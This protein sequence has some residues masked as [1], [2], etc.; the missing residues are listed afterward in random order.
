MKKILT[1]RNVLRSLKSNIISILGMCMAFAVAVFISIYVYHQLSIDRTQSNYDS[2]YRLELGNWASLTGGVIPW[3]AEQFP[4]V[5]S[6]ARIG[7]AF[8]ESTLEYENKYHSIDQVMFMDGEPFSVFDFNIIYGDPATALEPPN[9]IILTESV[10]RR[11]FN[12]QNPVGKVI[13]YNRDFPMVITAVI[14]DPEDIHLDFQAIINFRQLAGIAFGGSERYMTEIIGSQNYMG[15]FVLR[16]NGVEEL[17]EKIQSGLMEMNLYSESPPYSFRPFSNIYFADDIRPEMGVVHGNKQMVIALIFVA[18]F[19]LVIAT[20]NYINVSTAEGISRAREVG[21]KKL[22]GSDRKTLFAQFISESAILCLVSMIFAV[23]VILILYGWFQNRLGL[24][25]P[26]LTE[27]PAFMYLTLFG[28]LILVSIT[29]G[30]YP[31]LYLSSMKPGRLFTTSLQ[32]GGRGIVLRRILMLVQFIIAIFLTIQSIGIYKQY[33]YMKNSDPGIDIDRIIQFELPDYLAGRSDAI[34]EALKAHPDIEEISFSGQPLGSVRLT[35]TFISPVNQERIPF[36]LQTVDPEHIQVL[37]MEILSGTFFSRDMGSERNLSVVINET[38]AMA[39][40]CNPPESITGL[41][42]TVDGN[43]FTIIGVVK[44]Y[45]YNSLDIPIEPSLMIWRDGQLKASLRFNSNNIPGVIG[46]IEE[47]W[48]SFVPGKPLSYS[49]LEE[50]FN[51][52]YTGEQRLGRLVTLFTVIAVIIACFGVYGISAFMARKLSKNISLRK[53]MGAETITVVEHFAR[54]YFRLVVIAAIISIPLG[55]LYINHW[56]A[57]FPY[58]TNI[59]V[60]IFVVAFLLILFV[61][62]LTILYHAL[63]IATLNPARVLRYE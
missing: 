55:Y 12:D 50:T 2:I 40:G 17:E 20:I 61:T 58:Q 14:E 31:A 19:V 41:K 57:R 7:G 25:L 52:H 56:L 60:W 35:N 11:M 23:L 28:L 29:G 54:E 43:E 6:Y 45:N 62:I 22:L 8:W 13:N 39:M 18:L 24:N 51:S 5:E 53:V 27:L 36:K 9:A 21:L 4:E 48:Q 26:A 47:V 32:S 37:G 30:L 38:G 42:W 10:A 1:R 3:V 15:Y 63:K 44:D 34:R 49:F 16:S 33:N 46:H 59:A